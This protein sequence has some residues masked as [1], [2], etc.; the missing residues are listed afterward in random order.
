[1]F[2]GNF[3]AYILFIILAASELLHITCPQKM[4]SAVSPQEE[5]ICRNVL[6]GCYVHKFLN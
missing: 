4:L 2:R 1:M 3:L 5:P 6:L